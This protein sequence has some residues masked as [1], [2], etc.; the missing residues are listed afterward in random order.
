MVKKKLKSLLA[1]LSKARYIKNI[2]LT[3]SLTFKKKRQ[4]LS[5]SLDHIRHATL[6]LCCEEIIEKNI[7]GNVAE[8][9]VYRGHFAASINQVFP[10]RKLYLFDTF[11]GFA[12]SDIAI[13]KNGKFSTGEQDFSDTTIEKVMKKMTHPENCIFKKGF[14]PDT[15][16][17]V[18]D[19]FCFVSIDTDLFQPIYSGLNFFYPRLVNGGYIFVHDFNN[20]FYKG[21]K[22][23]VSQFCQEQR[24][25]YVP[26]P[27][28]GGTVI[29]IK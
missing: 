29:I 18:D 22:K 3:T 25:N 9:G 5:P 4:L 23:A 19:T 12:S 16:A 14:F 24:I 1:S 8:L 21:A 11:E 13:E 6:E 28:S 20:E 17:D 7:K 10:D 15:A 2:Y 26:L 27:D